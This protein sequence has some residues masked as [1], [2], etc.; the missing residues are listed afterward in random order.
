MD[1]YGVR[2]WW[3]S[4]YRKFFKEKW[5]LS[6]AAVFM[7]LSGIMAYGV[8]VWSLART[9]A[10][11]N[12]YDQAKP[13]GTFLGLKELGGIINGL[14]GRIGLPHYPFAGYTWPDGVTISFF[15]QYPNPLL[16]PTAGTMLGILFGGLVAALLAKEFALKVPFDK[17]EYSLAVI[18]G[19]L[20]GIGAVFQFGCPVVSTTNLGAMGV[21]AIIMVIGMTIGSYFGAKIIVW[22][23]KRRVAAI[24]CAADGAG[25]R[26]LML[27]EK[28]KTIWPCLPDRA[29]GGEPAGLRYQPY[30]A[31]LLLGAMVLILLRFAGLGYPALSLSFAA[32]T[33]TGFAMQ[34]GGICFAYAYREPF[35]SGFSDMSRAMA[36]L[37]IL[38]VL[39]FLPMKLL[40]TANPDLAYAEI[41]A[42]SPAGIGVLLGSILFGIGMALNGACVSDSLWRTAE[43]QVKIWVGLLTLIC[44]SS[45]IFPMREEAWFK[46]I[47]AP[48]GSQNIRDVYLPEILGGY[49]AA[50]A[51]VVGVVICW[52]L[53]MTWFSGRTFRKYMEE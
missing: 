29:D 47:F 30:L 49:P 27:F 42:I 20:M 16:E 52:A 48:Y 34:R 13:L 36:L 2:G 50:V 25:Y 1:D 43:G 12:P 40:A 5:P 37:Y 46:S 11:F 8:A 7:A 35:L 15:Q 23:E 22:L 44:V 31:A 6:T 21:Q 32:A 3:D 17:T 38:L 14:L 51:F 41:F 45:W 26:P 24:A 4:W 9:V 19:I 18:G 53:L 39:G 33:L 10:G 28:T